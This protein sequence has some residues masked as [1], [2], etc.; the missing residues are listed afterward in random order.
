MMNQIMTLTNR[1]ETN[2]MLKNSRMLT[3]QI[4]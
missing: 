2:L 4:F 1:E 3:E